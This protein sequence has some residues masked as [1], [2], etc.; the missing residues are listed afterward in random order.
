MQISVGLTA[1]TGTKIVS[2]REFQS[3]LVTDS[4]A[5][6]SFEL[7]QACTVATESEPNPLDSRRPVATPS[8]GKARNA[9]CFR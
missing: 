8:Q 6:Y 2:G 1:M 5:P 9:S 3:G 4:V 7:L